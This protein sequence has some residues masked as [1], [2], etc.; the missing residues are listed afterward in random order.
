[1]GSWALCHG[2]RLSPS[3][4]QLTERHRTQSWAGIAQSLQ[5]LAMGWTVRGSKPGGGARFSAPVQTS[6]GAHP[7]S[8]TV[9]TG[10]LPG[11][12]WPGRGVDHPH[13]SSAEVKEKVELYSTSGLS[14]SVT[15]RS[16][17]LPLPSQNTICKLG[18]TPNIARL[19]QRR[20]NWVLYLECM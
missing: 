9:G 16:L 15:G 7:A 10:S 8:Y 13:P 18:T 14:W 2:K 11:V 6:P 5:R 17:P 1:V 3:K 19:K 12:K 4:V 20:V